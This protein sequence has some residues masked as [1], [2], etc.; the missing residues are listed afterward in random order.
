MQRREN[1]HDAHKTTMGKKKMQ[2][3]LWRRYRS[4]DRKTITERKQTHRGKNK[5]KERKKEKKENTGQNYTET[6]DSETNRLCRG[7]RKT[8]KPAEDHELQGTL[9]VDH[10]SLSVN[11]L[12][13]RHCE[14]SR[15][16]SFTE[17][18][19]RMVARVVVMVVVE[20]WSGW[21]HIKLLFVFP[22]DYYPPP[23]HPKRTTTKLRV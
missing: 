22:R 4:R 9:W 23:P 16:L 10:N 8:Q 14:R 12:H 5:I 13:W 15:G 1:T 11:L 20:E 7:R 2:R 17:G 21:V 3:Q 19:L 6:E 18:M